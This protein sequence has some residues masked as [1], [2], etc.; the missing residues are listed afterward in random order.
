MKHKFFQN[1]YCKAGYLH[2]FEIKEEYPEGVLEVCEICFT[3]KYFKVVDGLLDN[4]S[5][6]SY[7]LKQ[8]MPINHPMYS[9]QHETPLT[10]E[11]PSPYYAK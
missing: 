3:R 5:Y 9:R 8:V 7:H 6:M 11:L 10:S 1:S 2:R 4:Q